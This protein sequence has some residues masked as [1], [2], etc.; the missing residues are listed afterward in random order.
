MNTLQLLTAI[1]QILFVQACLIAR[2]IVTLKANICC[3][4]TPSLKMIVKGI[5]NTI[6]HLTAIIQILFVQECLIARGIVT[7]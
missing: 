4:G 6:Q 2:G 5:L 3:K 1:I 7:F